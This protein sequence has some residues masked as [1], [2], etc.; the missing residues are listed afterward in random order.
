MTRWRYLLR[1]I[2]FA[3]VSVWIVATIAFGL[4]ALTPD[5]GDDAAYGSAAIEAAG[6]GADAEDV[7]EEAE[8]ARRSYREARNLDEP[9]WERYLSWMRGLATF[10]WGVSH[11]H[12]VPVSSLL[13]D[14][15]AVT[16]GYVLPGTAIALIGGVVLGTYSGFRPDS[17]PAR[18][19]I[20]TSYAAFGIPSFWIANVAILLGTYEYGVPLTNYEPS[21]GVVDPHNLGQLVLPALLLGTGL[22]AGQARF[23]R[24]EVIDHERA[25]FV[26]MVR[27]KGVGE[28]GVA[29][30]VLRVAMLPLVTLFLSNLL[31]ALVLNVFVLEYVFGLPGFGDLS[32]QAIVHRDL[33]LVVGTTMLIAYVGVF[34]T[35]V[36][37]LAHT[38][39]D[40]R[41]ELER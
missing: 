18:I 4:V 32:Y 27:A 22:L 19:T 37:N 13:V 40:P 30:H 2:A 41:V 24:A 20:G 7:I 8:E 31:G 12:D 34:G 29:W 5:P 26:R 38:A 14:R 33:P 10:E 15:L 21:L 23:V 39:M 17:I 11:T 9:V 36:K 3:I 6:Q 25:D 16:L 1:R 35:L 28:F